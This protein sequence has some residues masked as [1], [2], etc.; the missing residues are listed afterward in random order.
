M[1]IRLSTLVI[2]K[3]FYRQFSHTN[4]A[5]PMTDFWKY[6]PLFYLRYIQNDYAGLGQRVTGVWTSVRSVPNG[7]EAAW[8][9][10][11]GSY[12][13][14][15]QYWQF[16]EPNIYPNYDGEHQL[17]F[18]C[19]I[20][21]PRLLRIGL[22]FQM[23]CVSLQQESMYRNWMSE[24]CEAFNYVVCKRKAVDKGEPT[25]FPTDPQYAVSTMSLPTGFTVE[26]AAK[27]YTG[28][29]PAQNITCASTQF[30]FACM[31]A[32]A[33]FRSNTLP[34]VLL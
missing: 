29:S 21:S 7:S 32:L 19:T 11:P 25:I 3:V 8:V 18:L 12:V 31:N 27:K 2:F 13:L 34:M 5:W 1:T 6:Y 24:S 9:S 4:R 15:K 16:G 30:E 23:I 10:F 20:S 14:N 33:P 28:N 17:L 26:Y 22:S